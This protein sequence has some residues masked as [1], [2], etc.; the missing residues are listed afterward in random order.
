MRGLRGQGGFLAVRQQRGVFRIETS[1]NVSEQAL[2]QLNPLLQDVIPRLAVSRAFDIL[3]DVEGQPAETQAPPANMI[4][5]EIQLAP[6]I[7]R[8]C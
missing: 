4:W 2:G 1:V 7:C 6:R 5:P 3:S 8:K